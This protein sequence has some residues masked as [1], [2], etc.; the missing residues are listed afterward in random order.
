MNLSRI[1]E[2]W[3]QMA[4]AKCAVRFEGAKVSYLQLWERIEAATCHLLSRGVGPGDR[5]AYLGLNHP[6]Y[7]ALLMALA[8]IGAI[9]VPLNFR[10]AAA[11]LA[12][13]L[14]H[15]EASLLFTDA[16]MVALASEAA[17]LAA[18]VPV[19]DASE[20]RAPPAALA[21]GL[22]GSDDSDVLI[23]YTSG[24]T[25]RPKGAVHTQAGLMWNIAAATAAQDLT[26]SDH[27]LSVLP[28]F[29]VGGLCILTLPVL[30]A[31]GTVTLH[32]RFD[33][34]AWLRDVRDLRPSI[35]LL[36]PAT[37]KAIFDQ[38][39][40]A[41]A[42]LSSLRFLN[43]GSSVIP[44]AMIEAFHARGV[45]V[46]QVYGATETGPVSIVL[47]PQ[48]GMAKPG[49]AGKPAL[50]VEVKLTDR[51][52]N[53][54]APGEVGEIRLCGKNVMRGYWKDSHNPA[55]IDG[56]F[57][58]GDL[59]RQDADGYYYVVG[60]SKDMIISGGENIYPAELENLL[61]DC[62]QILEAAV[63]GQTDAKWG[64]VAVAAIVLQPGTEMSEA[65]VLALFE[66]KLARYK[67]PR[68]VLF[69]DSL[70]KTALGKVQKPALKNLLG[71]A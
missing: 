28:I 54:V 27:M 1:I 61:A 68:R 52:G 23:V 15:A 29:H 25:G 14:T 38:P 60:R 43:T 9:S 31:G 36:V 66:G 62:P 20:L 49:S 7:I 5:V 53:E 32:P 42:D 22:T 18:G 12:T 26:S 13:V 65:Q 46:S 45:A 58:T 39:G 70:P 40:W 2:H 48:D 33:P 21:T 11:E 67:H 51:E 8:R 34:N 37:I 71:G 57:A 30:A 41:S 44:L 64:E 69:L 63:V 3:A 10:L 47:R 35:S 4:P 19:A 24:T 17:T 59:A 50:H 16:A 6:D 55:F 56:W